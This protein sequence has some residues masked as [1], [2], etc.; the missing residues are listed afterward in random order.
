MQ[1]ITGWVW[2][3]GKK[4]NFFY[5]QT[6]AH[7]IIRDM[8]TMFSSAGEP[9]MLRILFVLFAEVCDLALLC[10]MLRLAKKN[11]LNYQERFICEL[12]RPQKLLCMVGRSL[13][14]F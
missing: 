11:L 3:H 1:L 7:I 8:Y 9:Q 5:Q 6:F 2:K 13:I 14:M 10:L 4:Q 12:C